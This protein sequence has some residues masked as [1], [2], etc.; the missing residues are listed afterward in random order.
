MESIKS[1][2]EA[3]AQKNEQSLIIRAEEKQVKE[4]DNQIFREQT[5][6]NITKID[7]EKKPKKEL[8]SQ[9]QTIKLM[10]QQKK[11]LC[12]IQTKKGISSGFL[13]CIPDP[14]LISS[15]KVLGEEELKTGKEII[16]SFNN[17]ETFKIINIDKKRITFTID[18]TDDEVE[19]GISIIEIRPIEDNLLDQEFLELDENIFKN[20]LEFKLK[21][22]YLLH[23]KFGEKSICS[24]GIINNVERNKYKIE[25]N[26]N[27]GNYSEGCPIL[28]YNNKVIAVQGKINSIGKFNKGILLNFLINKYYKKNKNKNINININKGNLNLKGI[29]KHKEG[30]ENVNYNKGK[31]IKVPIKEFS[32]KFKNKEN[33]IL[34]KVKIKKKIL[35]KKLIS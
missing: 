12:K 27:I 4:Q 14:V 18:K 17:D 34:I 32:E 2:K 22:I 35:A 31:L 24:T 33:E 13:C 1:K 11:S 30:G 7:I 10:N 26:V 9:A 25:H 15:N 3:K 28:L 29:D 6:K 8:L 21:N 19:V 23:Y 16:I 5:E 20:D